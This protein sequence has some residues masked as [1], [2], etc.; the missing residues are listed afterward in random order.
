MPEST[1]TNS[2][3]FGITAKDD[4]AANFNLECVSS[5]LEGYLAGQNLPN[6][7]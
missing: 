2:L 6:C 5:L 1:A 3:P 7:D 4:E